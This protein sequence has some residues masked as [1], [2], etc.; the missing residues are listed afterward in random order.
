MR[1]GPRLNRRN[2][3]AGSFNTWVAHFL[4]LLPSLAESCPK[5]VPVPAFSRFST[6]RCLRILVCCPGLSTTS[7]GVRTVWD[8]FLSYAAVCYERARPVAAALED[9]GWTVVWDRRVPED[10][11]SDPL[12]RSP[13]EARSV[14]VA[15]SEASIESER[16]LK[17]AELAKRT[18]V[19]IPVFLDPVGPPPGLEPPSWDGRGDSAPFRRLVADLRRFLGTPRLQAEGSKGLVE[20]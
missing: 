20:R 16:G 17:E 12:G 13:D 1:D 2:P 10:A 5:S 4:D 18:G 7:R 6:D 11:S 3:P 19:L 14:V 9:R 8:I 15:W